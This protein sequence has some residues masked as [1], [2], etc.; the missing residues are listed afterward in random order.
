MNAEHLKGL[1]RARLLRR[2]QT[3]F[4]MLALIAVVLA[5]VTAGLAFGKTRSAPIGTGVVVIDTNLAYQGGRAA[6]TGMVLTS[7][8]EVLT[9]NHVIRGA[10]TI[11]IVV[12]GTSRSY[13]AKVV[14]Y[15]VSDDVAVLQARAARRT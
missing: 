7:A 14:G 12:P 11:K 2:L 13:T 5:A 15:D 10:T 8:G 3:R 4:V 6:G 1:G 9:N